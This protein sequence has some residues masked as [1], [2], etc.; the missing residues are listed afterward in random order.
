MLA[1]FDKCVKR[2]ESISKSAERRDVE[3]REVNE[4]DVKTQGELSSIDGR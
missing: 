3:I 1:R 4:L 2:D